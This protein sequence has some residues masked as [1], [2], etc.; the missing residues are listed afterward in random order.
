MVFL[1]SAPGCFTAKST[2]LIEQTAIP[3]SLIYEPILYPSGQHYMLITDT[4]VS[5]IYV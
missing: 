2:A 1:N 5:E 3:V 4:Q